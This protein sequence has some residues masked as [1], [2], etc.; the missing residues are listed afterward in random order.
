M[1]EYQELADDYCPNESRYMTA[2]GYYKGSPTTLKDY[3]ETLEKQISLMTDDLERQGQLRAHRQ[4]NLSQEA[5]NRNLRAKI[6]HKHNRINELEEEKFNAECE[7]DRL[8]IENQMI[9]K[10]A[11]RQALRIKELE[12]ENSQ[13]KLSVKIYTE[14]D[15]EGLCE[16]MERSNED[17]DRARKRQKEILDSVS[18]EK[19]KIHK[20]YRSLVYDL[21]LEFI[22]ECNN[23]DCR[24]LC[25]EPLVLG[26]NNELEW[27]FYDEDND[28][29]PDYKNE[30]LQ[31]VE[32]MNESDWNDDNQQTRFSVLY[33]RHRNPI[34]TA[35]RAGD[36]TRVWRD[37][38]PEIA[39]PIVKIQLF[40]YEG[41]TS[42]ESSESDDDE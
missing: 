23:D 31:I 15:A 6:I 36:A 35:G 28:T 13:L 30:I 7:C 22:K 18:K 10:Q 40:N 20:V 29:R 32:V 12:E 3:I 33:R 8:K 24:D 11:D 27:G 42:E 19:E 9:D 25:D 41:N 17:L 16:F 26:N 14:N 4:I 2:Y 21:L 38:V 37:I 1:D 34:F 39:C 5:S